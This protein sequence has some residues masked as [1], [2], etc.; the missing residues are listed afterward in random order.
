MSNQCLNILCF[1]AKDENSCKLQ[2]WL[3][4]KGNLGEYLLVLEKE[5][6]SESHITEN[7][8][9]ESAGPWIDTVGMSKD[10]SKAV[11]TWDSRNY[12]SIICAIKLSKQFPDVTFNL[13]YEQ[14]GGDYKGNLD[15]T[16]GV[17]SESSI[18]DYSRE[19]LEILIDDYEMLSLDEGEEIGSI[20]RGWVSVVCESV[21]Q[22]EGK[23]IKT[24]NIIFQ[25]DESPKF[26]FEIDEKGHIID[27]E[28]SDED[29]NLSIQDSG[30]YHEMVADLQ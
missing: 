4:A 27:Y 15:I 13:D 26:V 18:V 29:K 20:G 22:E 14:T 8:P 21:K 6:S 30:Y 10:G 2:E 16:N 19:P 23:T 24:F 9:I 5:G 28:Y 25:C 17:I 1:D 3:D 11:I 12:P 7:L